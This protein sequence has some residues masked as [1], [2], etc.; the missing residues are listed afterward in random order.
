MSSAFKQNK[1]WS[2]HNQMMKSCQIV[3]TNAQ[4]EFVVK[5]EFKYVWAVKGEDGLVYCEWRYFRR[6]CNVVAFVK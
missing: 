1:T 3:E 6:E 5:D 4:K 2:V